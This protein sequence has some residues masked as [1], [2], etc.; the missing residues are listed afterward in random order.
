MKTWQIQSI[1]LRTWCHRSIAL[2][3]A[4]VASSQPVTAATL[5]W[6]AD[7]TGGNARSDG[8]GTWTNGSGSFWSTTYA[9]SASDVAWTSSSDTAVIG[10]NNGAAGTVAMASSFTTGNL[11]F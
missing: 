6:D 10:A 4:I 3:A 11:Q 1:S 5:F 9:G 7:G 2:F 8:G